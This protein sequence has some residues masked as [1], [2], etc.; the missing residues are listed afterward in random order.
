M[1][2]QNA[3]L[4]RLRKKII[5]LEILIKNKGYDK[6]ADSTHVPFDKIKKLNECFLNN[7]K[8]PK[9]NIN[10]LIALCGEILDASAVFYNK[11]KSGTVV[12][13]AVWNLPKGFLPKTDGKSCFCSDIIRGKF[14]TTPIVIKSF[15]DTDYHETNTLLSGFGFNSIIGTPIKWR[16]KIIGS[17]CILFKNKMREEQKDLEFVNFIASA[18][19]IEEDRNR[20]IETSAR[21]ESKYRKLF[22]FSPGGIMLE[23]LEGNI[24][25]AN[26]KVLNTLGYTHEEFTSMT[27]FDLVPQKVRY[28]VSENIAA[29]AEG[30]N[31]EHEVVNVRKDGSLC[32]LELRE[33]KIALDESGKEA[34]LVTCND[35]TARK[36]AELALKENEENLR[37][38]IN[39]TP[40]MIVFKD[41][42]GRWIEAN[43]SAIELFELKGTE[44]KGKTDIQL[45]ADN[46]F[47]KAPLTG[48]T[49]SDEKAFE[50]QSI[51]RIEEHI[52]TR[53]GTT[54]IFD[55]IKVPLFYP[56]G[57]RKGL[58]VYGRDITN[59]N[60][61]L[62]ELLKSR[63]DAENATQSKSRF[64]A[65]ISHEIRTPLNG[66]I[67][68][69]SLLLDSET[70]PEK[71][72]SLEIV[73][74]SGK[75][76]LN[77]INEILDFSKMES[78]KVILDRKPFEIRICVNDVLDLF[79][80]YC[81]RKGIKINSNVANDV[82]AYLLGDG[83]RVMQILTNLVSNSI[84][85]T[86]FGE[87]LISIRKEKLQRN[88][89]TLLFSV[90]DTGEGIPQEENPDIFTPFVQVKTH[91][92][93]KRGGTGLGLSISKQLA[94]LMNGKIWYKSEPGA[95]SVFFFTLELETAAQVEK[96]KEGAERQPEYENISEKLPL[97]ILLVEDNPI[98]QKVAQRILKKFGY[99][100]D[101][102][103]NGVDA[104][105]KLEK[106]KYDIVFMD[107]QMPEMDGL[108]ATKR[109]KEKYREGSPFI[110]A[111]TAA[112]MKGDREK[113]LEAGMVDY[114]PKPVVPEVVLNA[115]KKY[116][117]RA[118]G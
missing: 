5:D 111:M 36:E 96:S 7:T 95:G 23:D 1:K 90:S 77:L 94:E 57:K 54:R 52:P 28:E 38:L 82:P 93:K 62:N 117:N 86:D 69:T 70:D 89:I 45:A 65:T 88:K 39:S 74:Q 32:Y 59:F 101:V 100:I 113:C 41:K 6:P 13:S 92:G 49:A 118:V 4:E 81:D 44:Y 12:M 66:V 19:S 107:V 91:S 53:G 26:D 64:L 79:R 40:D 114:I 76:M 71:T 35:I 51:F 10:R 20:A 55:V 98:N 29:I 63:E 21:R 112:V 102:S 27:V 24:L 116:G 110:I 108:E 15:K 25:D 68:M 50:K 31:L 85:Y 16:N 8:D 46:P 34:I 84:K 22:N 18:V 106:K 103:V 73:R 2:S 48:C 67:G 58:I 17:L 115:L 87:I 80:A 3:E 75:S 61:V 99:T 14:E 33:T 37:T 72:E 9:D 56:N 30:R 42:K 78:G 109:I 105:R 104:L 47:I 11:L 60:A 97:E 83:A 43:S